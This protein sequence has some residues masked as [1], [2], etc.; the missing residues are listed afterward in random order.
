MTGTSS[1]RET[2]VQPVQLY[3]DLMK[4]VL[5]NSVYE[6]QGILY[7]D[8]STRTEIANHREVVPFDGRR[9]ENGFD[10]PSVAHTM[11]GRRRLDNLQDCIE[12]V[13]ADDVPGDLIETGVWRGGATIFMR[14][15]LR[16]YGITDRTVWVA[17]SFAGLPPADVENYPADAGIPFDAMTDVLGVPLEDVQENFRRYDLLDEQVRFL[18]GL[19]KDTLPTAPVEELAV[20]RLDG[21]MYEST[22]NAL[23]SLYPRLNPGGFAIID[24]YRLV[25]ACR[26]AV[27]DYRERHGISEP[28]KAIDACGSYWRKES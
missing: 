16:A 2:D 1:I 5:I 17:D 8:G 19:F 28:I 21:D 27:T 12:Q 22:M 6:D 25:P 23:D 18:P 26:Q 13:L 20:L 11:I 10:F 7:P 15:V 14:A 4:R 24:D 9:R 3:L